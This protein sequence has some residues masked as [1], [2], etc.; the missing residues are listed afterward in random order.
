MS[1]SKAF[2]LRITLIF[3][4]SIAVSVHSEELARMN[5]RATLNATVGYPAPSFLGGSFAIQSHS[6]LQWVIGT[7]FF[8]S[9]DFNIQT[10][11]AALRVHLIPTN[12]S[13]MVGAGI[14]AYFFHGQG[15]IQGLEATSVLGSLMLGFDWATPARWRFGGG[16]QFHYPVRLTF[17]YL[18]A[19][20][21][22]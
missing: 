13:P 3:V 7:G 15:D 14:S 6:A 10:L 18:E 9:S 20:L 4:S 11:S 1:F 8:W 22:F 12:F 17:P 19:G 5:R 21:T 2:F 16:L